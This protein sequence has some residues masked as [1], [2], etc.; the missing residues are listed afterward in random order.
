MRIAKPGAA[1][2]GPRFDWTGFVT[3]V[4]LDGKVSFCQREDDANEGTGGAGLCNEFGIFA[5]VG[6]DD[7]KPGEWF[8]KIGVGLLQRPDRRPYSFARPYELR[9]FPIS[10]TTRPASVTFR[11]TPVECRGYAV[12]LVKTLRVRANR[13]TVTYKLRNTGCKTVATH[14]YCHNFI[15]VNAAPIGPDYTLELPFKPDLGG[16]RDGVAAHGTSVTWPHTPHGAFF[17]PME[18]PSRKAGLAWELRHGPTGATVR[19][20]TDFPWLRFTLWGTHRVVSPEVF[21]RI[22]L[23]PGESMSWKRVY[24]FN[25]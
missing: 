6:F 14:E 24:D 16:R 23:R 18:R 5:P 2:S 7:A 20:T 9:P 22:L 1:Y 21:V 12:S 8:P 17:H 3:Q 11:V 4:T 15:A 13:L 19:E 10:V 25:C